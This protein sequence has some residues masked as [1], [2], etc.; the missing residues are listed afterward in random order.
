MSRVEFDSTKKPLD[1]LLRK[2]AEGL[3]Q[4]P[5]FQ[6]G[7][8]WDDEGIRGLLASISRAFPVGALMTLQTGGEVRF[9]PR[10]VE[11]APKASAT[12]DP[13]SLLL[14]G[15]QRIT[16]LYQATMRR[17]VVETLNSK[18]QRI[19]RWYYIDM[20][21]ALDPNLD[22]GEAIVGVPESKIETRNFGRD[23]VLDLTTPERE[24]E[25]MLFPVNR[26]F[27]DREWQHGFEDFWLDRD[28]RDKRGFYRDFYDK[29]LTAFSRYQMPVIELGRGTSREAV[30]LV[31]EKVN[32]G[33]KK[34]DAFEL[35]TAIFATDEFDLRQD[36][37]GTSEAPGR[38]K[39]L[40]KHNVLSQVQP[41]DL[42]QAVS[43]LHSAGRRRAHIAG[44]AAGDPPPVIC[45]RDA[46][47]NLP[48][49]AYREHAPKVE[50]GYERVAR[51]LRAQ[52]IH[53]FKD[54]PYTTQLVPLAAILTAIGDRWEE[55]AARR[56]LTRWYWCGVFGELYGSAVETRYGKD[57][58]EVPAWIDGGPEPTSVRDAVFRADRLDTMTSRLS[59]AYKGVHARLMRE[60]ARDFRSGQN[61]DDTVYFEDAVDIHH[62]FPRAWCEK[63]GVPRARYDTIVNKTPLTAKTNRIIGG[64]APSRYLG[65]LREAGSISGDAALDELVASHAIDPALLR[66]DDFDS[67]YAARRERLLGLIQ[68]S[69]GHSVY[70][71][72]GA[73]ETPGPV[74]DEEDDNR[75]AFP[76][77]AE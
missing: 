3:I 39:R 10:T 60:G 69:M 52:R 58:W 5:D 72:A 15:Q 31:F 30:C 63:N 64:S 28:D 75:E 26:I 13:E 49:A 12:R 17:E 41:T 50:A 53:W 14:D 56:K 66:A 61:Y 37:L 16:S 32:T 54:V 51:F 6:R 71:G 74:I 21:A 43:L 48:L 25:A 8:V 45:T 27:D 11:G 22:R 4:L 76:Q 62:V 38:Q 70:R 47:L 67:F 18:R 35:L 55:E 42:L 44:S 65:A 40:A 68:E 36:W 57:L 34:L 59:A 2:A 9:K 1:E 77:A 29:V 33:G 24:Y 23:V 46:I 73:D 20:K 19:K 7:W